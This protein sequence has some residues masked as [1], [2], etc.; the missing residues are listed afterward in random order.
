VTDSVHSKGSFI[1]LQLWALGRAASADILR[2]SGYD[3]VSASDIPISPSRGTPRPLTKDEIK[4]Y[5]QLYAQAAEN[6]INAGFDGVE[7][8]GY[9]LTSLL[10]LRLKSMSPG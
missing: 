10:K 8:H 2:E 3:F 4:E 5:V 1:Y 6:A 7:I 9:V